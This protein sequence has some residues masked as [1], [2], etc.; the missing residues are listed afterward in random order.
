[1]NEKMRKTILVAL[2][3]FINVLVFMIVL[4]KT[5]EMV[6]VPVAKYEIMPRTKITK[7]MIRYIE[8]PKKA[9]QSSMLQKT[10]EIVGK[11]SAIEGIIPKGSYFY[12]TV[13]TKEEYLKDAPSLALKKGESAFSLPCNLIQSAG[14]SIVAFQ[15]VD[16]YVTIES[17]KEEV[18][19]DV[20]L[21]NVRVLSIKDRKGMEIGK[22]DHNG[23]PYV[24]VLA[25]KDEQIPLLKKA[26]EKGS[27]D[28]YAISPKKKQ[29]EESLLKEDSQVLEDLV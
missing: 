15:H 7:S 13:I 18:K 6:K 21:K 24:C 27:V 28:I 29:K 17:K 4:T 2:V 22:E 9:I 20:L 12:K 10:S 5:N 3:A 25:I 16:L 23:I 1:M 26:L 11:I 19:S 8:V 14:N